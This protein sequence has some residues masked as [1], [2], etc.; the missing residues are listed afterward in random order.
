MYFLA[1]PSRMIELIEQPSVTL[2]AN[3]NFNV[4]TIANILELRPIIKEK[5]IKL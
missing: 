4:A 3:C 2:F 1:G 5:R